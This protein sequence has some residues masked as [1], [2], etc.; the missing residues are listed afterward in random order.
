MVHPITPRRRCTWP[1]RSQLAFGGASVTDLAG[2]VGAGMGMGMGG[3]TAARALERGTREG[4][5]GVAMVVA[6]IGAKSWESRRAVSR[7]SLHDHG[8]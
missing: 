7:V 8:A 5:A 2:T 1:L 3:A 4:L 6:V